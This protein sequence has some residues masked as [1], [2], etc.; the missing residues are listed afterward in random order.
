MSTAFDCTAA[1][2]RHL[3]DGNEVCLLGTSSAAIAMPMPV[4]PEPTDRH[5][6]WKI[7]ETAVF[8]VEQLKHCAFATQHR[9]SWKLKVDHTE[10]RLANIVATER[11]V[12]LPLNPIDQLVLY[13]I[14]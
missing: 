2:G 14:R 13:S 9:T 3:F 6:R 10:I 7:L 12:G 11:S 1:S 8:D 4:L 5:C